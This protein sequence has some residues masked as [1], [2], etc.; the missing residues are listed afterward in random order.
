M[1]RGDT[2][3]HALSHKGEFA[4]ISNNCSLARISDSDT[5]T[6]TPFF[7]PKGILLFDRF[8]IYLGAQLMIFSPSR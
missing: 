7:N 3:K 4:N 2:L 5:S 8:K 6:S 1:L